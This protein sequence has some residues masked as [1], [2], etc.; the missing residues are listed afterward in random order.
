MFSRSINPFRGFIPRPSIMLFQTELLP[1]CRLFSAA[2]VPSF[3]H[4]IL[5][6]YTLDRCQPRVLFCFSNNISHSSC[7]VSGIESEIVGCPTTPG[8]SLGSTLSSS[9]GKCP[10]EAELC[11]LTQIH[12]ESTV[13]A[14]VKHVSQQ[15]FNSEPPGQCRTFLRVK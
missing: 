4:Q 2:P 3:S 11:F 7:G 12:L 6:G 5:T 8:H 15:R 13:V 14:E 1:V 10:H 9:R